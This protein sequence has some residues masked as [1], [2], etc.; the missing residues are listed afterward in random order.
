MV[1][2][3]SKADTNA[4]SSLDA[5]ASP[6][7]YGLATPRSVRLAEIRLICQSVIGRGRCGLTSN[8]IQSLPGQ[9]QSGKSTFYA[10][11]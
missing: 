4:A 1:D 10:V 5:Q 7:R 11:E 2:T 9:I 6:D 3:A 8:Q